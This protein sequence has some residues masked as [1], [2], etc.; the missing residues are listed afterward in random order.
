MINEIELMKKKNKCL[1][2][3]NAFQLKSD[4][5]YALAKEYNDEIVQNWLK[6]IKKETSK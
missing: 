2:T 4:K 1:K 5:W 3:A 6:R